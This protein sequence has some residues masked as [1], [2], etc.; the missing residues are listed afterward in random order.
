VSEAA[1]GRRELRKAQ[2]RVDIR[3]AAQTLFSQRGFDGVTSADVAAAAGVA[4]QT[5]FNH[6]GSK[7]DLFFDGRTPW[8]EGLADAVTRRP[9][10][11]DP[12]RALR[13]Y[14]TADIEALHD[15]DAREQNRSYLEVLSSS[16][17]LQSRERSLVD[18]A[19]Q[20]L[21]DAL[22]EAIPAGSYAAESRRA[23]PVKARVLSQLA[24][25][26]FLVG[27]RVLVLEHRRAVLDPELGEEARRSVRETTTAALTMLEDSLRSLA[28]QQLGAPGTSA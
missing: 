26:L 3:T 4:V 21:A 17:A 16:P 14:L 5:V 27:G 9:P 28:R 6:F 13:E 12:L 2:T 22:L 20:R 1:G 25:H 24:A 10:G 15:Q 19:A 8:V 11:T 23:D 7:E 18:A